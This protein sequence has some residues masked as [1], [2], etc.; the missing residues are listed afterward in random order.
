VRT[1]RGFAILAR[2]RQGR[3]M[4]R[5]ALT[6]TGWL[7]GARG[8][9][10]VLSLGYLALAT[11]SLGLEGF[12][13]FVLAVS[14]SQAIAGLAS[15]QTW[16]AV[17]RWGHGREDPSRSGR[18]RARARPRDRRR[19]LDRR[20]AAAVFRRRLAAV[21]PALRTE[22]FWLTVVTLLASARRRPASCA[23]TTATRSRRPPTR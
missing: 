7:M 6:N 5:R 18:L 14:F 15:F 13:K 4:I 10:A 3:A 12:G 22:A 17:V 2:L 23:C 1:A 9:N 19:R 21:P 20:R 11:R 8:I 16:Q